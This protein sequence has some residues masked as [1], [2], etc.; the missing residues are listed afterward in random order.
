MIILVLILGIRCYLKIMYSSK[1]FYRKSDFGEDLVGWDG[2]DIMMLF[3]EQ[4]RQK[5]KLLHNV[6]L[7][8][9][10]QRNEVVEKEKVE[11][12]ASDKKTRQ[13]SF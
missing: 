3:K 10:M 8:M 6:G 12:M 2:V 5:N 9:A 1:S 13:S 4:I 7:E 11:S